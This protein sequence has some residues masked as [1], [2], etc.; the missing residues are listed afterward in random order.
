MRV[1]LLREKKANNQAH[2]SERSTFFVEPVCS[3]ECMLI[4]N[5][6]WRRYPV[7][8]IDSRHF[9]DRGKATVCFHMKVTMAKRRYDIDYIK[10]G[11]SYIEDK[12]GNDLSAL[13]DFKLK[14]NHLSVKGNV[15]SLPS[16]SFVCFCLLL[17]LNFVSIATVWYFILCF[18]KEIWDVKNF[19]GSQLVYNK[20]WWV[21]KP[22]QLGT[23]GLEGVFLLFFFVLHLGT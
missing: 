20:W 17:N 22:D 7:M 11:F 18:I 13:F 10:Y 6:R 2:F 1:W 14:C 12:R 19:P 5:S 16:H 15:T 21:L 9:T 8:L 4:L 3:S 23:T